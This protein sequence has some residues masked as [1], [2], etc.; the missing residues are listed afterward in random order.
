M[1]KNRELI[2]TIQIIADRAILKSGMF[3]DDIL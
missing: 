2:A 3:M 1:V